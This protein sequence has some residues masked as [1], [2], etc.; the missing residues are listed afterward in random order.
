M[1]IVSYLNFIE[2]CFIPVNKQTEIKTFFSEF[3]K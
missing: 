3:K 2:I 1:F